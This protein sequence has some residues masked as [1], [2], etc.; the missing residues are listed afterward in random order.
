MTLDLK[1]ILAMPDEALV[2]IG[3]VRE[4]LTQ[5]VDSEVVAYR[6]QITVSGAYWAGVI[7][8]EYHPPPLARRGPTS[9][10]VPQSVSPEP[11]PAMPQRW[12]EKFGTKGVSRV[13]IFSRPTVSPFIWMEWYTDGTRRTKRLTFEGSPLLAA[14]DEMRTIARDI[15]R[16]CVRELEEDYKVSFFR[17]MARS[18]EGIRPE[19]RALLGLN[20]GAEPLPKPGEGRGDPGTRDAATAT[21]S[22]TV[23]DLLDR[24]LSREKRDLRHKRCSVKNL[25]AGLGAD[26]VLSTLVPDD[27]DGAI[28]L[29]GRRRGWAS[30][31]RVRHQSHMR[32]ALKFAK[33]KL[34][35]NVPDWDRIEVEKRADGDTDHLTYTILE[36][37]P[38]PRQKALPQEGL[39][40]SLLRRNVGPL[41]EFPP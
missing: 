24:W 11:Q 20:A 29:L 26:R 21:G 10:S 39:E 19:A 14:S 18:A 27:I 7:R 38:L 31:T 8:G 35:W 4:Y 13:R 1:K 3:W 33:T 16:A 32:A 22:G 40:P 36:Y 6:L 12:S 17:S 9:H 23:G 41:F 34:E 30:S 37:G 2:P 28:D 15:A 5:P 25:K